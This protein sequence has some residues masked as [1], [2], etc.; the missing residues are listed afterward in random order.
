M[1]VLI[2]V[3]STSYQLPCSSTVTLCPTTLAEFN[4]SV[5]FHI[6]TWMV[7]DTSSADEQ[8]ILQN[9]HNTLIFQ[10]KGIYKTILDSDVTIYLLSRL[11]FI[12]PFEVNKNEI[13]CTDES[14]EVKKCSFEIAGIYMD[15]I[16]SILYLTLHNNITGI[17]S[18]PLNISVVAINTS[19][20]TI[21]L[22]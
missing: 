4:C 21:M 11:T 13:I 19:T 12:V 3:R 14:D 16:M 7:P 6:L 10:T 17:P 5:D 8:L 22:S 20:C 9:I 18:S 15:T 2:A 1:S